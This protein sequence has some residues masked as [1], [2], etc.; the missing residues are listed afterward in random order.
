MPLL[1]IQVP[2]F[3]RMSRVAKRALDILVASVLLIALAPLLVAVAVAIK[4]DSRG[5]VL[6]LPATD[7]T[8]RRPVHACSSSAR[9]ATDSPVLV[10]ED[11][12]IVKGKRR[13]P[14]HPRGP[15]AC[16]GSRSTRRRS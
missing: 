8:R 12:A 7:R 15:R 13:H 9:C 2:E 10:R 5:P 14:R 4:L 16:A 1:S 6:F 11:G 3:T